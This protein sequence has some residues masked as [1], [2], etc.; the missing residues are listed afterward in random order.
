MSYINKLIKPL[1]LAELL[2]LLPTPKQKRL[3]RRRCS[4]DSLLWG[5]LQVLKLG[6]PWSAIN[7]SGC[8]YVSCYRYFKELQRRG[9]LQLVY[10]TLAQEKTDITEAASDTTTSTSFRFRSLTGWDGK[11]RKVGT[12]ISLLTDIKGLP[13]DVSFGKGSKHDLH[14]I[15]TH[16]ENTQGTRIKTLNLD[17]GYTSVDLRRNSRNGGT[18]I[19]M[20]MRR[21][22][23]TAK[24]GPKF[25]FDR[26][27]YKVRF[28]VER[29]N[30]WL[31]SFWRVR[32]RRD[33]KVSM[34]KAFVYLALIIIL[35]RN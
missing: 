24:R 10:E 32:I 3:G 28:L 22:D 4:K 25:S 14:F 17:K 27:K 2:R 13:A 5:I 12:K 16:Q 8:S 29:T 19:N 21:R 20:E 11:H 33:Y 26:E 6:I 31:K 23:Y 7:D 15:S 1:V 34:F 18:F 35:I 30:A 9:K